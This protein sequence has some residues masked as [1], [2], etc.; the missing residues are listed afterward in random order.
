MVRA[1]LFALLGLLALASMGVPAMAGGLGPESRF[2]IDYVFPFEKRFQGPFWPRRMAGIGAGWVNFALVNWAEIEPAAPVKGVH[3]YDW[4]R[5]DEAVR[6]WQEQGFSIVFS[7]RLKA[8]WFSGPIRIHPDVG[9]WVVEQH[10]LQSDR[11][12]APEHLPSMVRWM[13]ALVERYDGDGLRDM[14]G[15]RGAVR[16]L[17]IGNEYANPM[18]WT[19]TVEDYATYLAL[20]ARA[21]RRASPDVRIV[22]NGIRWND[23]FDGDDEATRF[24]ARHE[25]F[26]KGLPDDRW[27]EL[28]RRSRR[29]TERTVALA[30]GYDVLDAGGNGPYPRASRGY[31][32]WVRR[33]LASARAT[34]KIWDMEAR[35]EPQLAVAPHMCFLPETIVPGGRRVLTAMRWSWHPRHDDM[36]AWYRAEQARLLVKVFVTRFSAG[37]EKVFMGMPD[38]WDQKFAAWVFPNPYLGLV[39]SD[40]APWPAYHAFR[41]LVAELDGFQE[42]RSM[43][44]PEGVELHRFTFGDGRRPIFIAWLRRERDSGPGRDLPARR[45]TL[46]GLGAVRRCESIPDEG[47]PTALPSPSEG[48]GGVLV[49]LS[50]TPLLLEGQ[51]IGETEAGAEED[52]QGHERR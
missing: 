19:G 52:P 49:E 32:R 38:D 48:D 1:V 47:S 39:S 24:E 16:H 51:A 33:R 15:L 13:E 14:P 30:P 41:R 7:L 50:T 37:F 36:V 29:M 17:Q 21:A 2:G 6:L 27:R 4:R 35:C 34:P 8:G 12:P 25:R 3:R 20:M 5:L 46:L 42:A 43:A 10:V 26:L 31:M 9:G 44:A 23:L 11:L 45:V 22:S 40:G 28:F 18:F